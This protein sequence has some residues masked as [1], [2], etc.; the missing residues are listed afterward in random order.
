MLTTGFWYS[1]TAM[2]VLVNGA[3]LDPDAFLI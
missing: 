1:S 3:R 2:Y